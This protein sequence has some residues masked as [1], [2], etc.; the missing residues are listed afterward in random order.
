MSAIRNLTGV[1]IDYHR[2][3]CQ[4]TASECLKGLQENFLLFPF[5]DIA[6]NCNS[7]EIFICIFVYDSLIFSQI[8]I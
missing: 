8:Y 6:K 3:R 4:L 1:H 5:S 7:E 2:L